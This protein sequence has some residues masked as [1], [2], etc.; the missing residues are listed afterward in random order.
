[1][2]RYLDT[3]ILA[4]RV[5][6]DLKIENPNDPIRGTWFTPTLPA[7]TTLLYLHGGGFA[8]YP[9]DSYAQF[10]ALIAQTV[11]LRTFAVDYRLT[12]EHRFPDP[13]NDT[14][15]AYLWLLNLGI[16]HDRIVVA[17]DSAGGNLTLALLCDLRDR[18]LPLPAMGIALSP[19]TEFDLVRPSMYANQSSDWLTG[20]MALA[21]RNWYCSADEQTNPLVSPIYA[22]LR[23]LPPIYIQAGRAEI[24]YDS[25][26]AF[27]DEA[28]RQRAN[29]TF[30][31]WAG[32]NHVFQFFGNDAPQSAEAL[33]RIAKL[34]ATISA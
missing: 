14:R 22:D 10:I 23:N 31:S 20:E 11:N 28:R 27:A 13:L 32:M 30:E 15:E 24:L 26:A 12:P 17:G 18:N 6:S 1:M 25:I 4:P 2:R 9:R 5:A 16:P 33:Q 3:L 34:I 8:L 19:A 21:W 29:V 7:S